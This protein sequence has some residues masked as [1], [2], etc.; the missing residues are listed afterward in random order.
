MPIHSVK[1]KLLIFSR[2]KSERFFIGKIKGEQDIEKLI[3]S[4]IQGGEEENPKSYGTWT[5]KGE[6]ND[7][8][9]YE[10][11]QGI[12]R[13]VEKLKKAYNGEI[14]KIKLISSEIRAPKRKGDSFEDIENAVYIPKLGNS[15]VVTS[16]VDLNIK[17]QNY[18][19]I[20]VNQEKVL[21][22]FLAFALNTD[23][24]LELRQ[25]VYHGIT[26]LSLNSQDVGE[27]EVPVP[28]LPM[29]EE[30]LK[31]ND[32][33][34]ILETEITRLKE[35]LSSIPASYKNVYKELKDINNRGD[36]FEQWIES[37]PYP[38]A[39][40]LKR[41]MTSDSMQQKQEM[42]LYFFEAY[43]IFAAAILGAI[44]NQPIFRSHEIRDVM[45]DYFEKASFGSWVKMDQAIA[46]MMRE[47]MSHSENMDMMLNGFHTKDQSLIKQMTNADAYS[48]LFRASNNRN[49]WKGHS[50]ISGESTYRDHV[51]ELEAE[52]NKLRAGIGDMYEKIRLVRQVKLDKVQGEFISRVEMLT[53]SNPIFKKDEIIGEA[54]D[55]DALYIQVLDTGETIELP[56]FIVMK[57]SPAEVK[58]ACYFYSRV[59]GSNSRYVSYHFE[60]QP[61]NIEEGERAFDVIKALLKA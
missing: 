59:E 26:I 50:G 51:N 19:Q 10:N 40:I 57:S 9:A 21:P 7:Y 23:A 35:R 34:N 1:S 17:P 54:L 24:G 16:L 52:L 47:Q 37:L 45:A 36:K 32:E 48:V 4:F 30:V 29:Q 27:I 12:K 55:R 11:E 44:Y 25:R 43:S 3:N 60:G 14:K 49:S 6:Y 28:S 15:P 61:E 8:A 13:A 38:L 33:L 39:T 53:G 31:V 42:L 58:N 5:R 20:L 56:P 2:E 46:K 22:R 41:Y 18:F